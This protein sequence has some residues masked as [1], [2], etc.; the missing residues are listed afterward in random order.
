M[1]GRKVAVILGFECSEIVC[2]DEIKYATGIFR[3]TLTPTLI[4]LKTE[5]LI[6][7]SNLDGY[8]VS[9]Q[10]TIYALR[11]L[12]NVTVKGNFD[13]RAFLNTKYVE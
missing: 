12:A 6:S 7:R 1:L 11:E 10:Q 3:G 13:P 5:D 4:E 8:Y 9:E 2:K